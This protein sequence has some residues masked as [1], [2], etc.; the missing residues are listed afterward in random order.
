EESPAQEAAPAA[1]GKRRTPA[2][3]PRKTAARKRKSSPESVDAS[4]VEASQSAA[5]E[6]SAA[7]AGAEPAQGQAAKNRRRGRKPESP[8]AD[9]EAD[10]ALSY[11]DKSEQL[12]QR[13]GKYL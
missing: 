12:P 9:R 8:D 5:A 6:S 3:K 11:L 1:A 2:A 10:L 7:P 4:V 13:L